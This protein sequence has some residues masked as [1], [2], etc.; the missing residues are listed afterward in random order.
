MALPANFLEELRARTSIVAVIGRTVKLARSG[1][2]H[3]GC[4]PF[5][6]EKTPSFY[7]YDDHFHCFGCGEHGDVI[8]F[9]MKASGVSFMEAVEDLTAQAG[10]E[11]PKPTPQAAQA[12]A[13]KASLAEVLELACRDYQLWLWGQE[14][15]AALD[16]LRRRGLTDETIKRFQLGWS[17]TGR[18]ALAAALRKYEVK[19]EQLIEA[20]LMKQGEH[21]PV[22]MFFD[23]VMF[24]IRDRRGGLVSFGGRIMGDSQPKYVN[25][26]ETALFSKRR[27]LYG[28]NLAREAVRKGAQLIVVEGYMDVIALSQAGF[29]GAVAPL[30]TA[31]TGEHLDEI[32]KLTPEPVLCFDGDAAGRRAALKTVELALTRLTPE[33]SLKILNL[34]DQDDPDSLIKQ[35]GNAAFEAVLAAAQPLS[36]VLY[37]M[38][39]AGQ[40]V[41]TPEGRALFRRRLLEAANSIPDKML[42]SEYR[43]ALMDAFFA[44]RQ[45]PSLGPRGSRGGNSGFTASAPA[46][47]A[48]PPRTAPDAQAAQLRRARIML[49]ILLDFPILIPQVEEAFSHVQLAAKDEPLRAALHIFVSQ[50]EKLD[51][52]SLE[53]H[54]KSAEL[55]GLRREVQTQAQ[56]DFRLSV[57]VSPAEAARSWWSLYELMDFSIDT[58]RT[59]RDEARAVW[60]AQPDDRVAWDR[61]VRYNQLLERARSGTSGAD[62]V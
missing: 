42:A 58:L 59:Q 1:R 24:P 12:E 57:D 47:V 18:G 9:V 29:G 40:S 36:A 5:H 56:A 45:K 14:G 11:V 49:A 54:L 2:E 62:E 13:R 37:N 48:I 32:W 43:S 8:S 55:D 25:G 19:T 23:R 50:A 33:K 39:K 15:R 60:L 34:P 51:R 4:C 20:G 38:L 27:S 31:L 21:G 61:L 46:P 35:G 44:K 16:Y 52:E 30:G 7:V 41:T 17:G 22:D 53:T 6:G 3:K 10:M 26:P 28:L